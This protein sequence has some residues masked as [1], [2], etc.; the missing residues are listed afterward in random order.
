MSACIPYAAKNSFNIIPLNRRHQR[1]KAMS[2][3]SSPGADP[4]RCG[5][6]FG[7]ALGSHPSH[8]LGPAIQS[9]L[10]DFVDFADPALHVGGISG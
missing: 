1:E 6:L 8:A 2:R 7:A 3:I 10:V 4:V 9:L 5:V